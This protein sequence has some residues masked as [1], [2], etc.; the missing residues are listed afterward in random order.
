L[1]ENYGVSEAS[2]C[3]K[4]IVKVEKYFRR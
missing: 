1:N 3:A 2:D 4:A